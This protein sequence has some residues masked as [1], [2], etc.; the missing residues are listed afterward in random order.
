MSFI[1]KKFYGFLENWWE[2]ILFCL[3]ILVKL[4][5][6]HIAVQTHIISKGLIVASFGSVLLFISFSLLL[7]RRRRLYYLYFLDFLL[8]ILILSDIYYYR[9]FN[10]VLSVPVLMHVI[11]LGSVKTSVTSLVNFKDIFFIFDLIVLVPIFIKARNRIGS[12]KF[13]PLKNLIIFITIFLLGFYAIF[14]NIKALAK[15]QPNILTSFYDRTYIV[16]KIGCLNFHMIDLYRFVSENVSKKAVS[17]EDKKI[18]LEW[19]QNNQNTG[20]TLKGIAKGKNLIIIQV[21]ALQ[22]F[23]INKKIGGR[24]ITPNLNRLIDRSLYFDNFYSQVADGGTSDAEFLTNV[25][26]F[27]LKEGAVYYRY[28]SNNFNSLAKILKSYGYSSYVM[29]AY[30]PDFWNRE[31]MYKSLGFDRFFSEKDYVQDEKIGMGLSD[32]SFF[33]QSIQKMKE[34]KKPFYA[35]LI[36]LSSHYPFDDTKHYDEFDVGEYENTLLG[37]YLKAIHYTDRAI[38][39]FIQELD[40]EGLLRDS[41][42]IIYG[43]HKAIP[44]EQSQELGRFLGISDM[45]SFEWYK[46]QKVPFLIYMPSKNLKGILNIAGGQVDIL[47]TVLNLLGNEKKYPLMGRD[48]MNSKE[49]FVVFRNGSFTDGN[50][51]YILPEGLIY[52]VNNSSNL[53]TDTSKIEGAKKSLEISDMVIENNLMDGLGNIR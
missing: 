42:V 31:L 3:V 12:Y 14:Y 28:S 5:M 4:I 16:N 46:L 11:L 52:S 36:T 26:F 49:G 13:S 23:V 48:L 40:K 35:F 34:F 10:D 24:E 18:M 6:F 19:F 17:V 45:N 32:R 22:G 43:D 39:E 41:I 9:Y 33:L 44:K 21:E 1:L 53:K 30:K 51:F 37:N 47:P 2:V 7:N 20:N 15:E 8:S 38:G 25:S 29:H 50:E 27:P